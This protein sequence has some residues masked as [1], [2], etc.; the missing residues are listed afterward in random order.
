[1]Y[2]DKLV[3]HCFILCRIVNKPIG[4]PYIR[5][6]CIDLYRS[7]T[8]GMISISDPLCRNECTTSRNEVCIAGRNVDWIYCEW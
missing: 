8:T 4:F 7:E 5:V 1:M 6:V 2:C 3:L